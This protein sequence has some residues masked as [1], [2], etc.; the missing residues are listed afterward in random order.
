L[1]NPELVKFERSAIIVSETDM[2]KPIARALQTLDGQADSHA[3]QI[4][5]Q[6]EILFERASQLKERR[7]ISKI[8]YSCQFGFQPIVKHIYHLYRAPDRLFVSM[9]APAE[10]SSRGRKS[11]TY[12]AK[13]QLDYDHT[14]EVMEIAEDIFSK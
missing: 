8:I 7:R 13:V 10:W 5:E 6:L 14:W 3:T 12:L 4:S 9:I 1:K 11:I 2:H